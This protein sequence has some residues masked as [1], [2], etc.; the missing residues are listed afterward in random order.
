M[1][2]I[3]S[4]EESN[5]RFFSKASIE[6]ENKIIAFSKSFQLSSFT[7]SFKTQYFLEIT[8]DIIKTD[9]RVSDSF[10]GKTVGSLNICGVWCAGEMAGRASAWR[11]S[12]LLREGM[13]T[14]WHR[15]LHI[16]TDPHLFTLLL[17]TNRS[18]CVSSACCCWNN[19]YW[20]TETN[21]WKRLHG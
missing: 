10:S 6:V 18:C 4:S 17:S 9:T 20:I 2:L 19:S 1:L 8:H 21:L 3:Q 5:K 15:S 14:M 16:L 13:N 12:L 11:G 7:L